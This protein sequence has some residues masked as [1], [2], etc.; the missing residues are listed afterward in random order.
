MPTIDEKVLVVRDADW[1]YVRVPLSIQLPGEELHLHSEAEDGPITLARP[2][3][4]ESRNK[5]YG[6]LQNF[7]DQIDAIGDRDFK[8]EQPKYPPRDVDF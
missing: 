8:V 4:F 6:D 3:L 7:F 5:Q 1:Q 2:P